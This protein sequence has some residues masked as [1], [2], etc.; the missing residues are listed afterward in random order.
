MRSVER[1]NWNQVERAQ[2]E[3]YQNSVDKHQL[4]NRTS[5]AHRGDSAADKIENQNQGNAKNC[6]NQIRRHAGE[7]HD[8]VSLLEIPVIARIDRDRLCATE[9]DSG[10]EKRHRRKDDRHE[11]IDVF[12]G[13]PCQSA[14]LVSGWVVV[15]ER[16]VTVRVLV[17]DHREQEDRRDQD[18][19]L[20]LVQCRP[21]E[22]RVSCR[23]EVIRYVRIAA[24]RDSLFRR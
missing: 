4:K 14:E 20:E 19:S 9:C 5:R 23:L 24:E 12:R 22:G 3:V 7:R 1:R 16:S 18:E 17:R 10:K 6:N 15:P 8:D 11:R 2:G 21:R 13:I